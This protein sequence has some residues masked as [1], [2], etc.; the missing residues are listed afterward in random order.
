MDKKLAQVELSQL[1]A[2]LLSA[3]RLPWDKLLWRLTLHRVEW[4]EAL[5]VAMKSLGKR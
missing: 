3:P 4:V 2:F 1:R 5:E